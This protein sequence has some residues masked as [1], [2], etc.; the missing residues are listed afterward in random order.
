GGEALISVQ[1]HRYRGQAVGSRV[2]LSLLAVANQAEHENPDRHQRDD[3]DQDEK[4]GEAGAKAHA[5][6]ARTVSVSVN[7]RQ[8]RRIRGQ[9]R[10]IC[11]R[12]SGQIA[13]VLRRSRAR[14][15]RA[16]GAKLAG[17][18][19]LS[20]PHGAIAQLGERLDRTQEVAGSS[21]ASSISL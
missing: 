15:P 17:T 11:S 16:A 13:E 19:R 8:T 6:S 12:Y 10:R 4:A 9:V 18:A 14:K 3:H 5:R 2:G 7:P 20:P 21:P 1:A